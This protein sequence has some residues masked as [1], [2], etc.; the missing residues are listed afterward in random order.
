M[1][2]PSPGTPQAA[3]VMLKQGNER[4]VHGNF[5]ANLSQ[6]RRHSLVAGQA[7]FAVIVCCSDSRVT[8]EL[9]FDQGLGDVFIVRVAGNV[10]D[11]IVLGSVEYAVEHL[12]SR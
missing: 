3:L 6:E 7:P 10:V 9:I 2:P 4:F 5:A 8:P 1:S 11:P 12:H